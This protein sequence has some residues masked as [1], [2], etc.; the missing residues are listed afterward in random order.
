MEITIL[1]FLVF[2]YTFID[3]EHCSN[4]WIRNST[5]FGSQNGASNSNLLS[6]CDDE[7]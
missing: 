4:P 6:K 5:V 1:P 3:F 2:Y 7:E